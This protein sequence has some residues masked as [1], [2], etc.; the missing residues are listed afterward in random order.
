MSFK[1]ALVHDWL[2]TEGGGEKCV[3]SFLNINPDFDLFSLID[4]FS[5]EYRERLIKGKH[6]QTSFIQKLP[7]AKSNHRKFLPLF[8]LAIEQFD[9]SEYDL[10]LSSSMS[11]S[12][13][14]L[15]HSNQTHICYCHSPMRYAWDLYFQYLN[16]AGLAT[17]AK[18]W[19]AK[20]ILHRMR[21]WDVIS[22]NRVDYFIANSNFIARRIKKVY[23]REAAVIYPPVDV[24]SFSLET[25]KEEFYL[26]ASRMVPYKKIDLIVEAFSQMP[27]KKLVVIGDGPDMNKIKQKATKNVELLGYQPFSSLKEHMQKAKAFVFAAEEDFGIIPVEAQACG[28][29]VIAYGRG[30]SLE[31]V[32][33]GKTGTFFFNQTV[34]AIKEA[35]NNFEKESKN[36]SPNDIRD[37]ALKF[38]KN[39]FEQ[40]IK[41]FINEKLEMSN[42]HL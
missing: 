11:V 6:A 16:E 31:T 27:D 18:G 7:T 23:N 25:N 36:F 22:S 19:L 13:G 24:D 15:T 1:S 21:T 41:S 40:E 26:T 17:G 35:V 39:R 30:G 3:Q 10:I 38:S 32:V 29:P 12:K 37:H 8:P 20:L 4:F 34:D 42:M 2:I 14:V 5:D 9:L 33:A 28:T